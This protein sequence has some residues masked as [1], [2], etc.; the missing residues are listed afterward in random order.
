MYR[1][2]QKREGKEIVK[3]IAI[4]K[5]EQLIPAL[6][7]QAL[8][9]LK[10]LLEKPNFPR[11]L[12]K[13]LGINEQKVYYYIK[14]LRRCGL[15]EEISSEPKRGTICRFYAPIAPAFGIELDQS[16]F[17]RKSEE[18]LRAF[19]HEFIKSGIF[20]G[21]IV[22]GSPW[23]HGPFRTAAR[24]GHYAIQLAGLLGSLC[25]FNSFAK[26]DVEVSDQ[27]LR[28]NLILIGGPVT[29]MVTERI[30]K[31]LPARFEWSGQW[32]LVAN[33]KRYTDRQFGLIAKIANPFEPT[34]RA[35]VLAGLSFEAT[36]ACIAAVAQGHG[37]KKYKNIPFFEIIR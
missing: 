20:D 37:I 36:K 4:V 3:P 26:L 23:P 15:I 2:V 14:K 21:L 30:N 19:F 17:V 16:G 18:P 31:R 8:K 35:V 11:E 10:K 32:C 5:Y 28:Q 29:N 9:I 22:V 34:K 12:A 1:L 24:D 27:D 33:G 25:Q 13:A 7:P 6:N